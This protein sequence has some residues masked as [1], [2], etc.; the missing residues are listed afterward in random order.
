M[1]IRPDTAADS[2]VISAVIEEAFADHPHGNQT[3]HLLV[4]GISK[5]GALPVSLVAEEEGQ[6]VGPMSFSPVK[7]GGV[8]RGWMVL[9]P[10][11]VRAAC[12]RRGIG[13]ALLSGRV[14]MPSARRG[15]AAACWSA[16]PAITTV[17]GPDPWP[18][19]ICRACH[20]RL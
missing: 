2:A 6:V 8:D 20:R 9:A 19:S 13:M 15:P 17:S 10:L 18:N 5:A 7:I 12:E 11:A 4:D 16:N 3:E 1:M 14:S